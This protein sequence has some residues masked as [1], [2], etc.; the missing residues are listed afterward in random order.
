MPTIGGYCICLN[1]VEM[2]LPLAE[3]IR[4]HLAFCDVVAVVDGG[5]LDETPIILSNLKKE[6]G[7]RL[8]TSVEQWD[9]DAPNM[10]GIQKTNARR[11]LTD[12]DWCWQFDIDEFLPHWQHDA[13]HKLIRNMPESDLFD[14]PCITFHGGM[15]TTGPKENC[16]KWRLSKNNPLIIHDVPGQFRKYKE[17]G[18]MY[19]NRDDA[20]SCEYIWAHTGE[21]VRTT[22]VWNPQLY[23]LNNAYRSGKKL[24]ATSERLY[25]QLL[26]ECCNG[27]DIPCVFHYSWVDYSRKASME[28]F[29][30]KQKRYR[31]EDT[32]RKVGKWIKKPID[33]ITN[34]DINQLAIR[35]H[36]EPVLSLNVKK[37]PSEIIPLAQER[38]WHQRQIFTGE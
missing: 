27:T 24:D 1:A 35:F 34:E 32:S 33:E 37:H 12:V 2:G 25:R 17:D 22:I 23:G 13:V 18:T 30:M 31:S 3:S 7:D 21:I 8:I 16:F 5:S 6:F 36:L 9:Y 15:L 14:L 4:N 10:M 20:D 38:K 28:K 19:F 11:L 29:W 26:S